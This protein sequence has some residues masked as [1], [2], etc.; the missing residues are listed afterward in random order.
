LVTKIDLVST[1]EWNQYKLD[2]TKTLA[3]K[4]RDRP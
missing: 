4:N 1:I 3:E 2:L